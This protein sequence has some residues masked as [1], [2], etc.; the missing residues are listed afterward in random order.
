MAYTVSNPKVQSRVESQQLTNTGLVRL[1][2]ASEAAQGIKTAKPQHNA[3]TPCGKGN[4][5]FA[6]G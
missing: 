5:R 1:R 6:E 2:L 3:S 4:H